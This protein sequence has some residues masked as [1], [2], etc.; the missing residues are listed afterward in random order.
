MPRWT[1]RRSDTARDVGIVFGYGHDMPVNPQPSASAA[2][3]SPGSR[4]RVEAS[5]PAKP[6]KYEGAVERILEYIAKANVRPGQALPPERDFATAIGVSRNVIRQSFSIL[7]ERGLI[8]TRQGSGRYLREVPDRLSA[9]SLSSNDLEVASIADI[10]E[11]RS[12]LEVEVAEL[13]CERRTLEEAQELRRIAPQLDTWSDNLRFHVA[14]AAAAHNFMIVR[15]VRELADLLGD[16]HQRDYYDSPDD[17]RRMLA[18]EHVQ[19]AEAIM[20]R[21]VLAARS[22]VFEHL[23]HTRGAVFGTKRAPE[24]L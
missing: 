10:L 17:R 13:A 16:L 11:T 23:Q 1:A 24:P 14:V 7:E 9:A 2:A 4:S 20:A 8:V 3:R 21:D 18:A 6:R 22:L 5:A 15:I 19:I 12:L